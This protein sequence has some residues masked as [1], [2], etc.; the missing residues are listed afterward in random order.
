MGECMTISDMLK[1][2]RKAIAV[3]ERAD[4]MYDEVIVDVELINELVVDSD[5]LRYHNMPT[6]VKIA[7]ASL[8]RFL[9]RELEMRQI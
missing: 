6:I 9:E 7:L 8:E 1:I 2:V 3:A 5:C 4:K